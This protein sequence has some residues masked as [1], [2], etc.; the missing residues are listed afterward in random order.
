MFVIQL[1]SASKDFTKCV[2]QTHEVVNFGRQQAAP[3]GI[4]FMYIS[5]MLAL[6]P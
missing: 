1:L 6:L 3:Y 2:C 4:F 5:K